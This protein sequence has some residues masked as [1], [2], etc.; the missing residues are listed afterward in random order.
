MPINE[1]YKILFIHIP[2]TAGSSI[3]IFFNMQRRE[4]FYQSSPA[5]TID[6]VRYAPQHFTAEI[7]KKKFPQF[8]MYFKF[9]FVRNPYDRLL[10]EY[11]FMHQG[12]RGIDIN[13]FNN[14]P[15][16]ERWAFGYLN[17]KG[18]EFTNCYCHKIEQYRY[19]YDGTGKQLI[20]SIGKYENLQEDFNK[21]LKIMDYQGSGKLMKSQSAKYDKN[22]KLLTD[23]VKHRIKDV[24]Y[25]DFKLFNY[26]F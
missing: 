7:M 6:T 19:L 22:K 14:I 16:F 10:S 2:K 5:Y 4:M 3:E 21:I 15:R 9:A 1:K 17:K 11:Y 23:K 26:K 13:F 20:Y 24:Y 12:R 8:D 18:K 25:A